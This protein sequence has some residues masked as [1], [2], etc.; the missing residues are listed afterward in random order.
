MTP[1]FF[2][3]IFD[4]NN[5]ALSVNCSLMNKQWC[6][7]NGI[8]VPNP[9]LWSLDA[10]NLHILTVHYVNPENHAILDIIQI[11][12]GLREVGI[13]NMD[14]IPRLTLNKKII[15][16]HGY[17]RH[18]MYPDTGA[19]LTYSQV[20]QDFALILESGSNYVRGCCYPQDQRFL[21]LCDENGIAVWAELLGCNATPNLLNNSWY[22]SNE[23]TQANEMIVAMINNS[24][25][26]WYAF[27]NEGT[28]YS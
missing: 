5:A 20:K 3:F 6:R 9:T 17:G 22:M 8:K 7:F 19:A 12:F 27:F 4:D 16:F 11:R 18:T 21:D 14:D 25:V 15:K 23:I 24:S 10:P 2:S 13:T 26:L 28:V 1:K